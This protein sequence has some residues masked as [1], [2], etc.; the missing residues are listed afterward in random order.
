M[1]PTDNVHQRGLA[2]AVG[3]DEHAA[4]TLGQ[5]H[6]H[7]GQLQLL[8]KLHAM[9]MLPARSVDREAAIARLGGLL[10]RERLVPRLID[11]LGGASDDLCHLVG[12]PEVL[13]SD[14][15]SSRH[16]VP[17]AGFVF[18]VNLRPFSEATRTESDAKLLGPINLLR[19][20]YILPEDLLKTQRRT[21]LTY[22]F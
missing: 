20:S 7:L 11:R 21:N 18:R 12:E 17:C 6:V 2:G 9:V 19:P 3:A 22:V 16:D 5:F 14:G 1:L 4:S 10:D 13:D 8:H 15:R